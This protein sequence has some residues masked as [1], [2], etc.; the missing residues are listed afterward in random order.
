MAKKKKKRNNGFSRE[1]PEKFVERL[2]IIFGQSRFR[3]IERT[4]V[5]RPTTFRIN[6]I[7]AT[8]SEV[9]SRLFEEGFK[10]QKVLWCK[11]AYILSNKSKISKLAN[12]TEKNIAK[13]NILNSKFVPATLPTLSATMLNNK[14]IPNE[15]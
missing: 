7:N 2:S 14:S 11:D 9:F 1:L 15:K 6:T 8:P 3:E 13:S 12:G 4:F 10:V 5:A